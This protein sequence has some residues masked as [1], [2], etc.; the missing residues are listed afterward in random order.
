M[1]YALETY[2]NELTF[3]RI[4]TRNDP[5]LGIFLKVTNFN[6]LALN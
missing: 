6:D 1:R 4:R 3:P 2:P 5:P